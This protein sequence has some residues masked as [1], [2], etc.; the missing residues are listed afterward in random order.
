MELVVESAWSKE[1][2]G[3]FFFIFLKAWVLHLL[4]N[5]IHLY[6]NLEGYLDS[7]SYCCWN[8]LAVPEICLEE[9]TGEI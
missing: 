2:S 5:K 9:K 7:M 3:I 8:G 4:S 6:H 1:A